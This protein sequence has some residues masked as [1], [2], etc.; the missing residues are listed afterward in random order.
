MTERRETR[1]PRA[2]TQRSRRTQDDSD[3]RAEAAPERIA[4]YL[5]R[6]GVASRRA[7]EALIEAGKVSVN[8][9]TLDT[10]AFK[11]TGR[12][13]IRVNG[14]RIRPPEP[15]RLWRYHKPSGLIATNSDPEGRRTIFDELP[16]SLPR[17]VTVGRLDLTTEGLL[18]LTND[19]ELARRLELPS[20]GLVRKYRARAH[21]R[22]SQAALD[23]LKDGIEVEGVKFAPITAILERET[24]ANNWIAVE[25]AEGRKREVR[26]ALESL[27]LQV[28]RLIRT[29]YGPFQL[30]TLKPGAVQEVPQNALQ[31]SLGPLAPDTPISETTAAPRSAFKGPE[32]SAKPTKRRRRPRAP[33]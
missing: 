25:L 28:N 18:L 7:A 1:R 33:S 21:G 14:K 13:T 6:C 4:K 5:A 23:T 32:S 31:S 19:G 16:S 2:Q 26:L 8:G 20:S 17:V 3:L 10:P 24:G 11:V 30:G 29:E 12:E 15:T 9:R 27:G 22:T